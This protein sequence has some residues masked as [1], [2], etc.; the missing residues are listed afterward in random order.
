MLK[1]GISYADFVVVEQ[2]NTMFKCD[3]SLKSHHLDLVKYLENIHSMPQVAEY[4]KS[5]PDT[6][7]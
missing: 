1:S 5:R 6:I 4:V 2:I 3:A 7:I